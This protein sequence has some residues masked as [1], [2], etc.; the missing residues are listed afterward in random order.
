MSDARNTD[1]VPRLVGFELLQSPE[2]FD[3]ALLIL[4]TKSAEAAYVADQETLRRLSVA[5]QKHVQAPKPP[6][7]PQPKSARPG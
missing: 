7:D 4:R 6:N 2:G 5:I 3:A 1:G